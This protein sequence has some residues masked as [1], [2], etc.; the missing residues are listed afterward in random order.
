M[1]LNLSHGICSLKIQTAACS[2]W[3]YAPDSCTFF[4]HLH[5]ITLLRIKDRLSRWQMPGSLPTPTSHS[6]DWDHVGQNTQPSFI[7][8]A[9]G[10]EE[11]LFHSNPPAN[12]ES[13]AE[14]RREGRLRTPPHGWPLRHGQ[15]SILS[16]GLLISSHSIPH[17][18][19]AIKHSLGCEANEVM[20]VVRWFV[21]FQRKTPYKKHSDC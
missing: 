19:S 7:H 8:E 1:Q 3:H 20:S 11:Q 13:K 5:S 12:A 21:R 9:F 16:L 10:S 17:H 18:F 4:L 2:W 6:E 15:G 14:G